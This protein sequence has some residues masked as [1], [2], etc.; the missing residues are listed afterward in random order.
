VQ[1]CADA[2]AE[3]L[4]SLPEKCTACQAEA[5]KSDDGTHII[6]G[7]CGAPAEYK[8][9]DD[10]IQEWLQEVNDKEHFFEAQE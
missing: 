2:V 7:E 4:E 10:L 1:T 5:W 8:S 9:G 6:C 3:T